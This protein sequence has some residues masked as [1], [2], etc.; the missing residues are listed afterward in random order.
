[1][2]GR[3]FLLTTPVPYR[4]ERVCRT[5]LDTRESAEDLTQKVLG[6]NT[7]GYLRHPQ[8][9]RFRAHPYPLGAIGV[10]LQA[11]S[12]EARL[13]GYSFGRS[14]IAVPESR[15]R[16]IKVTEGQLRFETSHH[17]TKIKRR[18]P[19]MLKLLDKFDALEPHP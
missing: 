17:A 7:R 10:Y 2:D 18:D 16:S 5:Y 19:G 9:E 15:P 6:G 12:G 8:I 1:M 4:R 11:V 14:K 13:R 3:A